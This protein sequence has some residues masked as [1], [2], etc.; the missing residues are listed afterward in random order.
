MADVGMAA[1]PMTAWRPATRVLFRFCVVY[2]SLYA[3]SGQLAGAVLQLPGV[4]LPAFGGL[5]PLRDLTEWTARAIF[6]YEGSL[7]FRGNSGDTAFH[8]VQTFLLLA[9]SVVATVAWSA[10]DRRV[11]YDALHRWFRLVVRFLLAAQMFY[12]GMAKVIP[13]QFRPLALVT[14]V[15]RVGNLSITDMLW[16]SVGASP[17]YQMFGGWAEMLAGVLLLFPRTTALGALVALADMVQVLALNVGYDFGLKGI[18]VHLMLLSVWLLAPDVRRLADVFLFDRPVGPSNHGE[19]FTSA[20]RN[21]LART[22]Q[23]VVGVY[24]IG[25]F[26]ML[27]VRQWT[28][29]GAPGGP[30]SPLYGIWD[31][32]QLSV[33]G[34][35]RPAE[36]NDYD[37]RWAR[38]IFD[39]P[40]RMAVQRTDDSFA[41][42]GVSIDPAART[43]SL[44]RGTS[45]TWSARLT[46]V[47]SG[48]D[49]LALLGTIDGHRIEARLRQRP[50]DTFRLPAAPF[51]WVRPPD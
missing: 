16:V 33:D 37:R 47:R 3:L 20:S 39:V 7:A 41:R 9:T 45:R 18:S 11:R 21:R 30:R 25:M 34:E 36:A 28:D 49:R 23:V 51:R 46:F 44:T 17:A 50:L 43:L 8:W 38:V 6:G 29:E 5:W 10:A 12:Y 13:T 27:N 14:L 48:D 4:Y 15:D 22:A 24:L 1:P 2:I 19:L 35:V 31:V 32:E 26:T 42:Y 40:S